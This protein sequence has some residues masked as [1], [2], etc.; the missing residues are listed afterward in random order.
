MNS[1]CYKSSTR[2]ESEITFYAVMVHFLYHYLNL[3][4]YL[5]CV[6]VK[7]IYNLVNKVS[8]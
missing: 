7:V 1:I 6:V 8:E 4:L 2:A 5:G 3:P